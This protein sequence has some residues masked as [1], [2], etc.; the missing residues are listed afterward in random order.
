VYTK[1]DIYIFIYHLIH[2]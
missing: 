2:F 1:L